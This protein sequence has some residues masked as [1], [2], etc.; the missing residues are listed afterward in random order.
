MSDELSSATLKE[1]YCIEQENN[2]FGASATDNFDVLN[3][4][5]QF[6]LLLIFKMFVTIMKESYSV[7]KL[8]SNN[9]AAVA[10]L[11]GSGSKQHKM[12]FLAFSESSVG[13]SG[14]IL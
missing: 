13:I 7:K 12:K 11:S 2:Y 9:S 6:F 14:W 5:A 3:E 8:S 10:L 4:Y 1:F